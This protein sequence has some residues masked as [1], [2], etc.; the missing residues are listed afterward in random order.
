[1]T[2]K[3]DSRRP[4]DA[5]APQSQGA[6]P[7]PHEAPA[8]GPV[9]RPLLMQRKASGDWAGH[10]DPPEPLGT[11]L[12]PA[13]E[14]FSKMNPQGYS[15][16]TAPA[17]RPLRGRFHACAPRRL[18][19]GAED[20][21]EAGPARAGGAASWGR[22]WGAPTQ[23]LALRVQQIHPSAEVLPEAGVSPEAL[24]GPASFLRWPPLT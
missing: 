14:R 23:E 1:M 19:L 18:Q 13:G 21:D 6:S 3:A 5:G 20:M 10:R 7:G 24:C 2:L 22:F 12:P 9:L 8:P 11:R 16:L 17:S 4:Q 15:R